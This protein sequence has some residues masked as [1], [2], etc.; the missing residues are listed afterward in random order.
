MI[1][2]Q[3]VNAAGAALANVDVDDVN[4]V[5]WGVFRN[6][7]VI[8]PTVVDHQAFLLWKKEAFAN[9]LEKWAVMYDK[10]SASADLIKRVHDTF[11]LM[12]VV[13]NDYV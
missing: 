11:Y 1:S 12:N 13:H 6:K 7:E 9:W 2:Y 10:D 8:Q 4:A 3:A 5:T